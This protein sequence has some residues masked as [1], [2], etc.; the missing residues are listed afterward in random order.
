MT[1]RTGTP[2]VVYEFTS[3][4]KSSERTFG[5]GDGGSTYI[6]SQV[7]KVKRARVG[8]SSIRILYLRRHLACETATEE[9]V[10]GSSELVT[11][12]RQHRHEQVE[13]M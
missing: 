4:S 11:S 2:I 12:R 7:D 9:L 10:R 8:A 1:T 5:A 3:V 13:H 6:N